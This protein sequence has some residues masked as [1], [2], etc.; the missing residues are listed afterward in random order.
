M[1]TL[2]IP[3]DREH[4]LI[5]ARSLSDEDLKEYARTVEGHRCLT[6]FACACVIVLKERWWIERERQINGGVPVK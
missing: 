6:C 1:K 2:L 5:K 3:T 4:Q